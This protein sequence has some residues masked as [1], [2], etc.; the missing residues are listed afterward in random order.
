[1]NNHGGSSSLDP[2]QIRLGNDT[3]V[4][5]SVE[6]RMERNV[7]IFSELIIIVVLFV[8]RIRYKVLRIQGVP[9]VRSLMFLHSKLAERLI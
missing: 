2:F 3:N 1:M 7:L 6:L 8:A 5:K 4:I 9:I